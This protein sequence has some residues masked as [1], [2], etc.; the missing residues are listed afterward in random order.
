MLL[1]STRKSTRKLFRIVFELLS[2][3]QRAVYRGPLS[4]AC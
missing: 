2:V 3:E 4:I 1:T